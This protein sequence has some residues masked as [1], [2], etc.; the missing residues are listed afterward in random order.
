M[1]KTST[2]FMPHLQN[3]ESEV[4]LVTTPTD[5]DYYSSILDW[6]QHD[7]IAFALSQSLYVAVNR[8]F[9]HLP[10]QTPRGGSLPRN[11][12][13][14]VIFRYNSEVTVRHPAMQNMTTYANN[15]VTLTSVSFS[16]NG[17]NIVVGASDGSL[18]VVDS[19][20]GSI[21]NTLIP[22]PGKIT[23]SSW[24]GPV[25][26]GSITADNIDN[27]LVAT[28]STDGS[29]LIHNA[30]TVPATLVGSLLQ[31]VDVVCGLSWNCERTLLASGGNENIVFIWDMRGFMDGDQ[32][33]TDYA[34][35]IRIEH[36]HS[37][38]R[39]LSFSPIDPLLI[40]TGGGAT[41]RRICLWRLNPNSEQMTPTHPNQNQTNSAVLLDEVDTATQVC[42]LLWS[43]SGSEI[44]SSHGFNR[45][46]LL[47]WQ[48]EMNTDPNIADG[49]RDDDDVDDPAVDNPF[50]L[51]DAPVTLDDDSELDSDSASEQLDNQVNHPL[52]TPPIVVED[53]TWNVHPDSDSLSPQVSTPLPSTVLRT[54]FAS[55][56]TRDL[57]FPSPWI[58][59][60]TS[61]QKPET[62]YTNFWNNLTLTSQSVSSP[63]NPSPQ[64]QNHSSQ[65]LYTPSVTTP[66]RQ[67]PHHIRTQHIPGPPPTQNGSSLRLR[68]VRELQGHLSRPLHLALSPDGS[69]LVS[70]SSDGAIRK[71][72]LFK[73]HE[74]GALR[75]VVGTVE[76]ND[77]N[78][79]RS[80]HTPKRV[81]RT[82]FIQHMLPADF[83]HQSPFTQSRVM[84]EDDYVLSVPP[85]R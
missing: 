33:R 31:H 46:S 53:E 62:D 27:H 73:A 67:S 3:V 69:E 15:V 50:S 16:P 65:T 9:P 23:C 85:L 24:A 21:L 70:Y 25:S 60:R 38:V 42:T 35:I 28:A 10:P 34:P 17:S 75:G 5:D 57:P 37:A 40:A 14:H 12:D 54:S 63:H 26:A 61:V 29:I 48:V 82:S 64:N 79:S 59:R 78:L 55:T 19:N 22:H 47:C 51:F 52:Q 84:R 83:S 43:Q 18:T 74:G 7:Q 77:G 71:W 80:V 56:P 8:P 6:G 41:D 76:V 11:E 39:A 4:L 68:F 45:F 58:P 36:H 66:A 72:K 1:S 20:D 30:A 49:V 32:E 81:N 44:V 2:G 13:P